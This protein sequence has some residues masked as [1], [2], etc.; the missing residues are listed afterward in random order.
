M[1]IDERNTNNK[2]SPNNDKK[3]KSIYSNYIKNEF[4]IY[5]KILKC[6]N[7]EKRLEDILKFLISEEEYNNEKI[8]K[9]QWPNYIT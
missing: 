4:S 3:Y 6:K 2:N 1:D 8:N 9:K 5:P 7:G